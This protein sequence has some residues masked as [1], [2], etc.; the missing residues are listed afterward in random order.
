[1]GF[2]VVISELSSERCPLPRFTALLQILAILAFTGF[3]T[4]QFAQ[5][6]L[7][8][9]M[10]AFPLLIVYYLFVTNRRKGR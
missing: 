5:G 2:K 6:N 3:S 10:A 7:A 1:M 9:G 8:G 4:W